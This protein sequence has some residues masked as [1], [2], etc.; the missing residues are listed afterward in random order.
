MGSTNRG[1]LSRRSQPVSQRPGF[2]AYAAIGYNQAFP[3]HHHRSCVY[4]RIFSKAY[5][6]EV[7]ALE[8]NDERCLVC[9]AHS[10]DRRSATMHGIAPLA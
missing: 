2:L 10:T 6:A 1:M 8:Q 5:R 3:L 9:Y 7:I 4:A